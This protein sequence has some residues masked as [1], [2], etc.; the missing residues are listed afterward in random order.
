MEHEDAESGARQLVAG[1]KDE[2]AAIQ[3]FKMCYVNA[4]RKG[5]DGVTIAVGFHQKWLQ[6]QRDRGCKIELMDIFCGALKFCADNHASLQELSLEDL[7]K[8]VLP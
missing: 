1:V 7:Q 2:K 3:A 5:A 6:D 4:N 8:A